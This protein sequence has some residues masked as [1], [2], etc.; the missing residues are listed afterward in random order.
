MTRHLRAPAVAT[1]DDGTGSDMH[2]A[3]SERVRILSTELAE[4][5]EALE[6]TREALDESEERFRLLV[7][8]IPGAVY[9]RAL[10]ADLTIVFAG[11]AIEEITGY[12]AQSLTGSRDLAYASI[13]HPDDRDY[14][15][16]EIHAAVRDGRHYGLAYRIIRADGNEAWV[17]D[18]GQA[19]HVGQGQA[20]RLYGTL[21]DITE[22]KRLEADSRRMELELR[23]AQKL[24]AVGQ[25]AAGI[26]HEINTPVQF[27]GDSV[28]FLEDAFED[29]GQLLTDYREVC[30]AATSNGGEAL[31]ARLERAE[32]EAD[33]AYLKERIPAA[34]ERTL[35]GVERVASI[36]RAMK[37][38]AHPQS[39]QA[40]ADLNRALTTTL[41]VARNEYKYIAELETE[42]ATLPPVVCNVSDLNQVFLNL[43]VNAAHAIE[44]ARPGGSAMGTIRIRTRCEGE[45]VLISIA[46]SGCGIPEEIRS[47][48][49]DPFFTTKAVGRGSGQGL[50]IA[51]AIVDRHGGTIECETELG[52]GTTFTIRLPIQGTPSTQERAA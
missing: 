6:R 18:R 40:P 21:S 23:V 32:E 27:V 13:V 22:R 34:F 4:T 15:A 16:R 2:S 28:R 44:D 10:D 31:R 29:L 11:D 42:L 1:G 19:V 12:P 33:L 7:S 8:N 45:D 37:E 49:F 51:R 26:A 24:E 43:I 38:F 52:S 25:L 36:V 46:D 39:E 5:A 50:A 41:T 17:G 14:V 30:V 47:R 20:A 9:T 48:V 35:E 3:D